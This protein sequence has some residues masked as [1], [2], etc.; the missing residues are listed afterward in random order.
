MPTSNAFCSNSW[1]FTIFNVEKKP[2]CCKVLFVT[3]W[4][5][6]TF[7]NLYLVSK[8]ML[9]AKWIYRLNS[10]KFFLLT[11]SFLDYGNTDIFPVSLKKCGSWKWLMPNWH[12]ISLYFFYSI[13]VY[14]NQ[15]IFFYIYRSFFLTEVY[16]KAY[17][18]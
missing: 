14:L 11:H 10:S 1:L 4:N 18:Q 5:F 8:L 16:L 7:S 15:Y 17:Q 12:L 6:L 9:S 2:N 3:S 13:C